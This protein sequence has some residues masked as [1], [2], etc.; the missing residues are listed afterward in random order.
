M[1]FAFRKSA[2]S[3]FVF[4]L[5][6][7]TASHAQER[8]QFDLPQQ[9]LLESLR[10]VGERTGTNVLASSF[11]IA[12]LEAPALRG[13]MTADEAFRRLLAGSGLRHEFMDEKTVTFVAVRAK[14]D[15]A[16]A[17]EPTADVSP[18]NEM[19]LAQA[20]SSYATSADSPGE[21]RNMELEEVVVTAQ[22]RKESLKDVPI[23]ISVL[24][25]ADLDRSTAKGVSEALNRV[26]GVSLVETSQG[27]GNQLT[28]RG[29]STSYA[30]FFGTSTAAYYLD[31]MPFGGIVSASVP[32]S[33]AYDLDR[34]EVLRG[35]QGTLYGAGALNGVVRILTHDADLDDFDLK[36]RTTLSSTKGGDESYRGDVAVNLPLLPGK[37]AARVVAGYEDRGG[38][39]DK[40]NQKDANDGVVKN[41][42]LKVNAQPTDALS[43]GLMAWLSREDYN[44]PNTSDE[45]GRSS[46][47]AREFNVSEYDLYGLKIG[48]DFSG[49][50]LSSATSYLDSVNNS[51]VDGLLGLPPINTLFDGN[52]WAEELTLTS[53]HEGPWRWSLGSLYRK[54]DQ[55]FAQ[56]IVGI[57]TPIPSPY[58]SE[59]IAVFGEVTRLFHDG[60][61]ELTG[62]LRYFEDTVHGMDVIP[63][64]PPASYGAT[65]DA[66]SPRLVFTWHPSERLT[67]YASYSEGFRSGART[68]EY[69]KSQGIPDLEPDTLLNYE[70]GAKGML[71]G[72]RLGFDTAVFYMDWQDV[73][74][75]L[76]VIAPVCNCPGAAL[77]NGDSA[78]GLGV[79]FA[80]TL[81]PVEDLALGVTLG[82]NDLTMDTAVYTF[83]AGA[84]ILLRDKGE[85]FNYSPEW[86][87]GMSADYDFPL[88]GTGL[89]GRFSASANYTSRQ[90][91]SLY[92]FGTQRSS[93][94]GEEMLFARTSFGIESPQNWSASLYVDNLTNEEGP[95]VLAPFASPLWTPRT[96]PRTIGIQLEYHFGK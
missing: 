30:H 41:L 10:A 90:I 60:E 70:I 78:S 8:V 62:G 58:S 40:P 79:D 29:V 86:T 53:T 42:R 13:Q 75:S 49:F 17:I 71:W 81:A 51:Q 50:S 69:L 36:A 47:T 89:E 92:L 87:V 18:L 88:G 77:V 48:Y 14:D 2:L 64:A 21:A 11:E 3:V 37:L 20:D 27:A 45:P 33:N 73:Q 74:E 6:A 39:I 28:V 15:S 93:T 68:G 56:H 31:W 65:F 80:A 38:W 84:P 9:K 19:R 26:P 91:F 76:T 4:S 5:L 12:G 96:R 16:A 67:A 83:P 34:V 32:D 52:I 22:R 7:A 44:S 66:I 24:G 95:I 59:S 35:P 54:L 1:H 25:G 85:R 43:I 72:G 82:W 23:S 63:P 94:A 57:S 55:D 46:S 61:F